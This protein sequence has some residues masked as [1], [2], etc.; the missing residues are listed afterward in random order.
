M[1]SR[2]PYPLKICSKHLKLLKIYR[3]KY[4]EQTAPTAMSS[5][6]SSF[7]FSLFSFIQTVTSVMQAWVC[8]VICGKSHAD[9]CR[10]GVCA[11]AGELLFPRSLRMCDLSQLIQMIKW[12]ALYSLSMYHFHCLLCYY[13]QRLLF[14]SHQSQLY[15]T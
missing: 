9:H 4:I 13:C 14:S 3:T 6:L 8:S 15:S 12:L 1:F 10:E 5:V 11:A 7:N 2:V